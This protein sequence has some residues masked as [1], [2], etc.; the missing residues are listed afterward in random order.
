MPFL[1]K[2]GI[3]SVKPHSVNV[4]A[5]LCQTKLLVCEGSRYIFSSVSPLTRETMK[6]FLCLLVLLPMVFCAEEDFFDSLSE[7]EKRNLFGHLHVPS[8]SDMS[9]YYRFCK[10]Y[11]VVRFPT[12][13]KPR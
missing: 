8:A 7:V 2:S 1:L 3:S 11:F 5:G 6:L 12:N 10:R 9:M 13:N 4:Q